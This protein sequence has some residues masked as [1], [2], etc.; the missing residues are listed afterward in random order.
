MGKSSNRPGQSNGPESS[1]PEPTVERPTPSGAP[2]S[3][4]QNTSL[5][6]WM[7]LISIERRDALVTVQTHGG[8]EGGLWCRGGNIVD[9]RYATLDGDDAVHELLALET[10]DFSVSFGRIERPRTVTTP[11]EALLLEVARRKEQRVSMPLVPVAS[12]VSNRPTSEET[13]V[14]TYRPGPH[15]DWLQ[16]IAAV[17][18]LG[19]I[20]VAGWRMLA[21]SSPAPNTA[22]SAASSAAQL[23]VRAVA[24]SDLFVDIEVEPERAGIWLDGERVGTGHLRQRVPHDGRTHELR[25]AAPGYAAQSL[26]F[27]EDAPSRLVRLERLVA[28]PA[29]AIAP[30]DTAKALPSAAGSEELV[31]PATTSP[32]EVQ[33]KLHSERSM[34]PPVVAAPTHAAAPVAQDVAVGRAADVASG[35]PKAQLVA[36]IESSKPKI[37]VISDR[38]APKPKVQIIEGDSPRVQVIE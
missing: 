4:H 12:R 30:G 29:M 34:A 23:A 31:L 2:L 36:D 13:Q 37:H 10:G 5:L 32:D 18:A 38:D 33:N 6:E 27:R 11:T 7:W 26:V 25:L 9:A 21:P 19:V 1:V 28:D 15:R 16:Q 35:K 22:T 14:A 8:H 24:P 17:A 3:R 20:G